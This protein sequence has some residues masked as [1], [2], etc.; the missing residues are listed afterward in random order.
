MSKSNPKA[1]AVGIQVRSCFR[2]R[3]TGTVV[4]SGLDHNFEGA[5]KSGKHQLF[6]SIAVTRNNEIAPIVYSPEGWE[7]PTGEPWAFLSNPQ[8]VL[9]KVTLDRKG[10]P[11][12]KPL[13]KVLHSA[14]LVAV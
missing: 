13:W 4:A 9:V 6:R 3:W 1:H 12:R 8:C 2:A 14:W 11:M 5:G 10:N 7:N